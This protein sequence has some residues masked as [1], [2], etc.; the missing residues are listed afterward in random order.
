MFA[1]GDAR[2][3]VSWPNGWKGGEDSYDSRPDL[4]FR[5]AIGERMRLIYQH[6]QGYNMAM[7][8]GHVETLPFDRVFTTDRRYTHRWSNDDQP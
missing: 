4:S 2:V 7:V 5:A 6:S 1:L 8:D 3:L